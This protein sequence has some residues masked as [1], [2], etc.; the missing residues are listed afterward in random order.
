MNSSDL[1][2]LW[3]EG[4]RQTQPAHRL[5]S[6]GERKEGAPRQSRRA[7]AGDAGESGCLASDRKG[8]EWRS[9]DSGKGRLFYRGAG[10]HWGRRPRPSPEATLQGLPQ[11]GPLL[12]SLAGPWGKEGRGQPPP[13]HKDLPS[14]RCMCTKGLDTC[15]ASTL[16]HRG[17]QAHGLRHICKYTH[18][19]PICKAKTQTGPGPETHFQ[20]GSDL[21]TGVCIHGNTRMCTHMHTAVLNKGQGGLHSTGSKRTAVSAPLP[22]A[23]TT[24]QVPGPVSGPAHET[25]TVPTR[26][27]HILVRKKSTT[28]V[29]ILIVHTVT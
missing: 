4:R 10:M 7:R 1:S 9:Q 6:E 12:H 22:S 23:N 17:V 27:T 26:G 8:L 16:I 25:D 21:H 19:S 11:A 3:R 20:T 13:I 14:P 5:G 29:E 18:T 28:L 2:G 24:R 15:R